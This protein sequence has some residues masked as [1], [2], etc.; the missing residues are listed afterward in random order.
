[1]LFDGKKYPDVLIFNKDYEIKYAL[2]GNSIEQP[3][4]LGYIYPWS[5]NRFLQIDPMNARVRVSVDIEP[6]DIIFGFYFYEELDLIYTSLDM[7]PFGILWSG[8][9]RWSSTIR[10]EHPGRDDRRARPP[11][12]AGF[13]DT[14]RS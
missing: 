11:D 9:R 3:E 10:L 14:A 5:R 4:K 13:P 7:N 8:T 12:S 6:D 2:D 1:M